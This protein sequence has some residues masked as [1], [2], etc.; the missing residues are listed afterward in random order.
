MSHLIYRSKDISWTGPGVAWTRAGI[1][2]IITIRKGSF[3]FKK[4]FW[5]KESLFYEKTC[6]N[7]RKE[8]VRIF[9]NTHAGA[10]NI[11]LFTTIIVA[12]S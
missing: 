8:F 4:K 11:Q 12:V 3:N 10:C 6:K 1:A 2:K 9:A 7:D 5:E